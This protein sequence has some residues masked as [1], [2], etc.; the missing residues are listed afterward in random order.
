MAGLNKE[1]LRQANAAISAGDHE[2]FLSFC[3]DDIVWS[4][5]GGETLR[6]K[7]AVRAWM[8]REYTKPPEFDVQEMIEDGDFV[9]AIG[10]IATEENGAKIANSYC[11]V[12]SV[13]NGRLAQ[14]RAFV[15]KDSE[16]WRT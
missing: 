8:A 14:L 4:T 16:P 12:W 11:D 10:T 9:V 2:G 13:K 3:A 1:I 7:E 15:I 5:V 6:G